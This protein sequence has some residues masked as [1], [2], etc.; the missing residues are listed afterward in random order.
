MSSARRTTSQFPPGSAVGVPVTRFRGQMMTMSR[1]FVSCGL[2]VGIAVV[3]ASGAIGA[4]RDAGPSAADLALIGAVMVLVHQNYV[5][6]LNQDQLTKDALKGMLSRLDPHSDYMDRHEFADL[7]ASISGQFGGLGIEISA[8]GG[9]AKVISPIDGTPAAAAGL[10][11][12][13]AIVTVGGESTHGM[14]IDR[15]VHKLRGIPGTVVTLGISRGGRSPFDVTL[16][17]RIIQVQTVKSKLEPNDTGYVRI[18]EFADDTGK[19]LRRAIAE[20]NS[21]AGGHLKGFVLDLRDDPG[22]LLTSAVNVAGTFLDGGKVVTIHG[23]RRRDD[24]VYKAPVHGDLLPNTPMVV[25]INGASAS[26]SEIVAGALQDRHRATTMGTQSFG[27]GSVQT[28]VS[29]EGHGAL[30]LTTAFYYT[31]SGRSIQ[32]Q[33]ISPDIIVA[34]PKDQQVAATAMLRERALQGAI[35]NPGPLG[36]SAATADSTQAVKAHEAE[37]SAPIKSE[38]IGTPQDAQLKAAL[39]YLDKREPN[40][41]S[42]R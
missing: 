24:E 38:L 30:R 41:T 4:E 34:A 12:G 28:I 1:L 14:D 18:S 29:L 39:A 15:L 7:Q 10:Q 36:A 8:E 40:Q 17:R 22:G 21:Q 20:L 6:P 19:E 27:K 33:G 11:P 42:S 16:T 13:D 35:K 5:H 2:A 37:Y 32:D 26:A 9:T 25:L 31:P 3:P 23:R